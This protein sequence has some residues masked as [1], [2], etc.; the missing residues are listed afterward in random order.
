MRQGMETLD[1][2]GQVMGR[3]V[4]ETKMTLA[5]AD[6]NGLTLRVQTSLEIGDRKLQSPPQELRQGL[7]GEPVDGASVAKELP[8][9]ALSIQGKVIPCEVRQT[10]STS[11]GRRQIITTWV[12]PQ[13]APFVMRKVTTTIDVATSR[14]L[15]ETVMNVVSLSSERR[16]LARNRS[17]AEVRTVQHHPRG[18]TTT[19]AICCPEIPG[20]V[21]SQTSEEFDVGGQLIR[22]T[23]MELVDFETK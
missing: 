4:S 19:Q 11:G 12:N 1:P 18:Q 5:D 3:S 9:E 23:Q 6:D 20:G 16:I 10:E 13:V 7:L 22:R 17:V 21:V 8:V 2:E 15:G 14:Q